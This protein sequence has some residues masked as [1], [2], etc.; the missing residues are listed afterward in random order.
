MSNVLK[1]F[2]DDQST[3]VL[4]VSVTEGVV[5]IGGSVTEID[6]FIVKKGAGNVAST[7]E[8]GDYISGWIGDVYVAGKVTTIPVNDVSDLSIAVQ[9]E[10]L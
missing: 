2:V 10:I 7:I 4:K 8:V 6:G 1:L 5:A 9:G 3:S